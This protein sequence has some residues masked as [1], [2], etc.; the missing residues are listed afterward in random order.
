MSKWNNSNVDNEELEIANNVLEK[1]KA[2]ESKSKLKTIKL[3]ERLIVSSN[4][5]DN[6]DKYQSHI[7]G[8]KTRR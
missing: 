7:N 3:S 6:I 4:N 2:I 5:E 1:M 8:I